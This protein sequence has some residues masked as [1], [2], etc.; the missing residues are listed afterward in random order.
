MEGDYICNGSTALYDAI[1]ETIEGLEQADDTE[2]AAHLIIVVTDGQENCSQRFRGKGGAVELKQMIERLKGTGR[3]TFAFLGSGQDLPELQKSLGAQVGNVYGAAGSRGPVGAAAFDM[4]SQITRGA[5]VSYLSS[6]AAGA[7]AMSVDA[8]YG[9]D[10]LA[11]PPEDEEE[12]DK[13]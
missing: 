4:A 9:E 12:E 8:F 6:M 1:A 10:S 2:E 13:T 3:W 7:E 11:D 5:T